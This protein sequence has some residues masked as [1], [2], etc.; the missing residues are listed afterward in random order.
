MQ[1]EETPVNS[2]LAECVCVC[3][4]IQ[5]EAA[6]VHALYL[7]VNKFTRC[8]H[9]FQTKITASEKVDHSSVRRFKESNPNKCLVEL[10]YP[11]HEQRLYS[12]ILFPSYLHFSYN[13]ELFSVI[14]IY[15]I[16]FYLLVQPCITNT[17]YYQVHVITT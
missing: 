2:E 11:S 15:L 1:V 6:N 9:Q 13:S 16:C 14:C 4:W 10:H 3:V 17:D 5:L 12:T 7:L 8:Q